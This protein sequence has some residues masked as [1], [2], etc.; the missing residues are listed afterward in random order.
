MTFS[1]VLEWLPGASPDEDT[2]VAAAARA[3]APGFW[4]YLFGLIGFLY[5]NFGLVISKPGVPYN[6]NDSNNPYNP[7]KPNSPNNPKEF[8]L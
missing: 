5:S 1:H 2:L 6:P 7:N 8:P 3:G 4:L